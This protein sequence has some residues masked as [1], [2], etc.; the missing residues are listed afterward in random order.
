MTD[1]DPLRKKCK[2]LLIDLDLDK[3]GVVPFL[4]Q[5]LSTPEDKINSN[6]LNMT[7]TGY[8]NGSRSEQLLKRLQNY[9]EERLLYLETN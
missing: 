1:L 2:K 4:A 5:E 7:L 6:S 3:P 9:L 8:R